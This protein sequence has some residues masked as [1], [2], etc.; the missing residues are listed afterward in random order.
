M[1]SAEELKVLHGK[2]YAKIFAET[3][4]PRR[5]ERLIKFIHVNNNH[6]VADLHVETVC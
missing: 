1:K 2:E 5:L 4:S 3:Q 6:N